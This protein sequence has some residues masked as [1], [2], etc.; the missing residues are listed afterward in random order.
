[1]AIN[2]QVRAYVDRIRNPAKRRYAVAYQRYLAGFDHSPARPK[3]LSA[4]AAQA[5]EMRLAELMRTGARED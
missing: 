5:V 4:M 3:K 2:H 1:M